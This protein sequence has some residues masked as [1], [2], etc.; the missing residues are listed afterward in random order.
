[1]KIS[2]ILEA[3]IV[4]KPELWLWSHKRWKHTWKEEY[5]FY[6]PD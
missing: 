5:G 1:L 2:K 4:K 6:N 3:D